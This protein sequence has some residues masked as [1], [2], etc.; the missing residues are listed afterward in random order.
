MKKLI[1]AIVALIPVAPA[2]G[3]ERTFSV[4]DFDRIQIDGS[5][6]VVLA[7]GRPSSA[8]AIGSKEGLDRVSIDVQSG[9]LRI[10][11]NRAVLDGTPG[12]A[13]G[14]VRIEISTRNVQSAAVRGSGKLN[15][16]GA[17]GLRLALSLSGSGGLAV[18]NVEADNLTIGLVGSGSVRIAGRA[19]QLR[20]TVQGS[21]DLDGSAFKANDVQLVAS[22]A[23]AVT[24]GAV[25][26][27]KVSASGS[28]DV[29]ILG[30]PACTVNAQGAGIVRCGTR[31]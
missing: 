16:D 15:I 18:E 27:A 12:R 28:G 26:S 20:A 3:A 6:E 4:A 11:P 17:R 19:K 5:Y 7:T 9:T 30:S 29:E 24:L 22:T 14:P 31:K 13:A 23:G 8:K 10:R 1:L 25:R 21:G 2:V